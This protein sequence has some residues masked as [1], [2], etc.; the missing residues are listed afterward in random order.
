MGKN[1]ECTRKKKKVNIHITDFQYKYT[2]PHEF[3]ASLKMALVPL[4]NHSVKQVFLT[5]K[6]QPYFP[7]A[8]HTGQH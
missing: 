6:E 4:S 5:Q 8:D 2:Y 7:A 1:F 3:Q